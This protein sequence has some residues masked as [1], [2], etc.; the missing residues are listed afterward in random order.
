MRKVRNNFQIRSLNLVVSPIIY[1]KLK[2]GNYFWCKIQYNLKKI[3][4]IKYY[5]N[6]KIKIIIKINSLINQNHKKEN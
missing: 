3:N 4:I 6:P 2:I 1:P 5:I